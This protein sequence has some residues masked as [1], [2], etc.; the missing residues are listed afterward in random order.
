MY[1]QFITQ[2][3]VLT[4]FNT[5]LPQPCREMFDN[6]SVLWGVCP[7]FTWIMC[8]SRHSISSFYN[9][10]FS[11]SNNMENFQRFFQTDIKPAGEVWLQTRTTTEMVGINHRARVSSHTSPALMPSLHARTQML[12]GWRSLRWIQARLLVRWS[13]SMF[14]DNTG[15]CQSLYKILNPPYDIGCYPC[16]PNL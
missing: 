12:Q 1:K 14:M 3:S 6:F 13:G 10:I 7:I 16:F 4:L 2:W 9:P 15:V 5:C 8:A 11:F